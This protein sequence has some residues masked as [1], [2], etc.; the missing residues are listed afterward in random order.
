[1]ST[2][3]LVWQAHRTAADLSNSLAVFYEEGYPAG[4]TNLT[5]SQ[6]QTLA[7]QLG[8]LQQDFAKLGVVPTS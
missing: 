1:M 4:R 6:R 7:A 5:E 2:L 3:D 8:T